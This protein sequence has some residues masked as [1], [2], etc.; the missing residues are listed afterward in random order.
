MFAGGGQK[1]AAYADFALAAGDSF[2]HQT[3]IPVVEIRRLEA[4]NPERRKRRIFVPHAFDC[5]GV[6]GGEGAG[7]HGSGRS[8]LRAALGPHVVTVFIGGEFFACRTIVI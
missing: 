4:G 7:R 3:K 1:G 8:I 6:G 2:L 5:V